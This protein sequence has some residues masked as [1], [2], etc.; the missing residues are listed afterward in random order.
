[1][2]IV[3]LNQKQLA[4]RWALSEGTLER[5]RSEGIGPVFL[6]M[7]GQVRYRIVDIEAFEE[8]SLRCSTNTRFQSKQTLV[9]TPDD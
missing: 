9:E 3:L 8:S 4:N 7:Q 1:M 5:W 6:K 2:E